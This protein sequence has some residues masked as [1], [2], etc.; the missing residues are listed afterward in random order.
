MTNLSV[1]T[2]EPEMM[3][4]LTQ[5]RAEID[6]ALRALARINR[7][8]RSALYISREILPLISNNRPVRILDLGSGGGDVL[9]DISELLQRIGIAVDAVGIDMNPLSVDY[10]NRYAKRRNSNARFIE[11][12][13][14]DAVQTL[15]YDIVISSLFLHHFSEEDLETLFSTIRERA[16]IGMIMSDLRRSPLN[17]GLIWLTTHLMSRSKMI[18]FDGLV[19]AKAALTKNEF[20]RLVWRAKL[21]GSIVTPTFPFRTIISWCRI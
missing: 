3:D 8:S 12:T 16:T 1:R 10:A 7:L 18:R 21:K 14:L 13:A 20:E 11:S 15:E 5:P 6:I 9:C 17:Y 4:D 19:S 2:R